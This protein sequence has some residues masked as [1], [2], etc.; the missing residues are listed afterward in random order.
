MIALISSR[1]P[2]YYRSTVSKVVRCFTA[3]PVDTS[4]PRIGSFLIKYSV[5]LNR[6]AAEGK[7]DP[8]VGREEEI[9]RVLQILGKRT[10]NNPILIGE[11]GVGKTAIVE[12]IAR[13]IAS[14]DVPTFM[15]NKVIMSLDLASM[16]AGA[17]FRGEFEERLKGTLKDVELALGRVILFVDEIH[18]IVGAGSAEGAI[19][20]SN[21]IKPALARGE[22]RCIGATTT[23]EHKKYIEKDA[24]LARRFQ[25]VYVPEPTEL[26]AITIL[27]GL[28][29]KYSE[30][31]GI[32]ITAGA[33]TAAVTLS[34]RYITDRRLPDKAID[35]IDEACS[36]MKIHLSKTIPSPPSPDNVN[37]N[38]SITTDSSNSSVDPNSASDNNVNL[39]IIMPSVESI[40]SVDAPLPPP[41]TSTV[42]VQVEGTSDSPY[43]PSSISNPSVQ[44]ALYQRKLKGFGVSVDENHIAEIISRITRMPLGKI[45]DS[46]R[47]DLLSMEDKLKKR[48]VG[49]DGALKTIAKCIRLSRAGLRYHDRPLG[50]F[51]FLGKSGVGKT[52]VAKAL[53]DVLFASTSA[54]TRLDMSE[55]V[56]AHSVSRLVGAP[57]GYIGYDQGGVLTEAVRAQPYQIVLFDEF[58]KANRA[59]G[60]LLLQ[61]SGYEGFECEWACE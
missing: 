4:P 12:G 17:K 26:D 51:L 48:V 32:D 11:P 27:N 37:I 16:L 46:E 45:V 3:A 13:R 59:V 21:M 41:P 35:L 33:I 40:I 23:E 56:E 10:K 24:A 31:H 39:S 18:M 30:H 36:Q 20:A 42:L 22:L 19:D 60:N 52:E 54:M 47:S 2:F 38:A 57:P 61:V 25:S 5:N 1:R 50:V 9:S 55:Y 58:E 14:G 29:T 15:R 49:Q 28:K 8:V 43:T 53:G 6:I 44:G 7:L 34:H